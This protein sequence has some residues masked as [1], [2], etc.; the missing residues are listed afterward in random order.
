M[1]GLARDTR[2]A[3]RAIRRRPSFF[4]FAALIIGLGVAASTSVFSVMNALLLRPLP[5]EE[6]ER[7][8]WVAQTSE[9]GMSLVTSRASNLRDYREM[10]RSFEGLTGYYAFFEYES[11]NLVGVG[12]PE[13][14]VGVGVAQNFLDVLGVR[15]LLGR[16]FDREESVWNGR[17]AAILTHGFWIRRFGGDPS[18]VGQSITLNDQPTA[19]VGVLPPTFDFASTFAPASRVD[20]LRPFP[21]CDETDNW[22]NTLS[23]IG[24]LKPGATIESAQADLDVITAR[25]QEADPA[26]WGLGA[27]VT[28]LHDQIAGEFRGAMVLLAAAA[29]VVML[30]V[31]TNLS[32][33]LL[34][35]GHARRKEMAVRSA[36]GAGPLRLVRLWTVE[37][38]IL[39]FVGGLVGVLLASE[40]T[41]VVAGTSAISI[42]MLSSVSI[43]GMTLLFTIIVTIGVGLLIGIVPAL[44][45]THPTDLAVI[46]ES[47]RGSTEGRRSTVVREGLVVGEVALACVLLVS[48]GLLLRSFLS[49]LD[50]DLGFRPEGAAAWEVETTRDFPNNIERAAFYDELIGRVEA[51]PGVDA[52]GLTD[53]PPLGRNRSW[54]VSALGAEYQAGEEPSAFP[55]IVDWRYLS[56]MGIPISAGRGFTVDDDDES[57]RVVILNETAAETLFPG[58]DP[59][60]QTVVIY[61]G[62]YEVIG[63]VG[64]VRHQSLEESSGLEVYFPMAQIDNYGSLTM[65]VRSPLPLATLAMSVRAALREAD[66]MMPSGDFWTLESVVDRSISPRRFILILVGA[67][68][69]TALALAALGIYAV[70]SFLVS[71][72]IPEIGIRMALG[73]S[74]AHVLRRVVGRTMVLAVTGVAIGAAAAIVVSRLMRSL[75][76]G[77][78]SSD[79][80]TFAAVVMVLLSASAAAG[81]LPA[82][83][84]SRTD[85]IQA[86]RTG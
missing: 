24:R 62:G 6:A 17:P 42:P 44:Q 61:D 83:R 75:L 3:L 45:F 27:V 56:V 64:N 34:A 29:G 7:L 31:C 82:W 10:N 84:A 54:G 41:R 59:L 21:I 32:N 73:E 58:Q 55:R 52:A 5:F 25:L 16:N 15:P 8:V 30:I 19:V 37:S 60:G 63:I 40:I 67:F 86:L 69:G 23:I 78:G 38:L 22:G 39:A 47:S 48:G 43:D 68:A 50:V 77:I 2:Y 72:R 53:T 13:R 81:F 20:F 79:V 12:Q 28:G 33:L 66:P 57:A 76:Y 49:V 85:P 14:L 36:L 9:S 1:N 35:R 18:I 4:A 74:A 11:Y 26:R 71:Q 65:V 70:L 80:P 51:T 46:N